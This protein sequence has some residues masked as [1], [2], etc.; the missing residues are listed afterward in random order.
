M[1]IKQLNLIKQLKR[2]K[3]NRL[4]RQQIVYGSLYNKC[5]SNY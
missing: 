2:T 3:K 1:F 5:R 4:I